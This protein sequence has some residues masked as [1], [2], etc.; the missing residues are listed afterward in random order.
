MSK[1]SIKL[2]IIDDHKM[3]TDGYKTLLEVNGFNVVGCANNANYG[4]NLYKELKPDVALIDVSMPGK[5]GLSCIES[6]V[7]YDPQAK[8]IVCT[9]YD[10]FEIA[11]R[12]IKSGAKGFITKANSLSIMLEAINQVYA[13]EHY[14]SKTYAQAIA[15]VDVSEHDE[16]GQTG[17][18]T[19]LDMLSAK[20]FS[21]FKM[22][23]EGCKTIEIAEEM[24]LS[25]KT[26]ANYRSKILRKIRA[27]NTHELMLI[28]IRHGVINATLENLV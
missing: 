18:F 6:I 8:L 1:E 28:A 3:V 26:V 17:S 15:L 11:A 14:L 16:L 5:S 13:G 21:I 20:E 2:L 4:Y 7:T 10:D 9:M 19:Q 12:A 22:V 24:C 27:K 23:A 25:A